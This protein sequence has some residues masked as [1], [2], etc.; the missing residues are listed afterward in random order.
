MVARW[1]RLSPAVIRVHYGSRSRLGVEGAIG[2]SLPG[3]PTPKV[4]SPNNTIPLHHSRARRSVSQL[5]LSIAAL[6]VSEKALTTKFSRALQQQVLRIVSMLRDLPSLHTS[7]QSPVFTSHSR[8]T[9]NANH[10][11]CASIQNTTLKI[12][13]LFTVS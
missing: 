9:H 11:I 4:S 2:P 3:L 5:R 6:E 1:L 12:L 7:L 8:R 10:P 13:V